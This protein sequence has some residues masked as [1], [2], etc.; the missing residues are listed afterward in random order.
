[1]FTDLVLPR[2]TAVFERPALRMEHFRTIGV[3][4]SQLVEMLGD[5]V[6]NLQAFSVSWLPNVFGVDI[7]SRRLTPKRPSWTL[8]R[9]RSSTSG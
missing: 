5:A 8:R 6:A 7:V 3:G 4:E 1:M 2:V 9:P